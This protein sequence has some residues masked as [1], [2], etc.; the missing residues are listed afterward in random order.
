[1]VIYLC[2]EAANILPYLTFKAVRKLRC[3]FFCFCLMNLPVIPNC[4]CHNHCHHH[5]DSNLFVCFPSPCCSPR[6]PWCWSS[7]RR[8]GSMSRRFS[9][10]CARRTTTLARRRRRSSSKRWRSTRRT[11]RPTSMHSNSGCVRK[12][13]LALCP[14]LLININIILSMQGEHHS[15]LQQWS[16]YF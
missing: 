5:T 11:G 6:R 1:M 2:C 12:Q 9:T 14:N 8:R 16:A 7:W 10:R 13:V 3:S 4:N 15:L